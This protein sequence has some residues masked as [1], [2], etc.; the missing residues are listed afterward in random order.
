MTQLEQE[1]RKHS[2]EVNQRYV[3]EKGNKGEKLTPAIFLNIFVASALFISSPKHALGQCMRP[4]GIYD[5]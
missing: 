1:K 4:T 2:R 5:R 3:E